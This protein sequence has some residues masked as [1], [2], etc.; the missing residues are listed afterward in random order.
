ML[1]EGSNV[2]AP[3]EGFEGLV[4]IMNMKG[5]KVIKNGDFVD[6]VA[7]A[8]EN[9][10]SLGRYA[11]E[12]GLYGIEKLSGI[13]GSGGAVPIQ[14][15]GAYG[16]E[17]KNIVKWVEVFDTKTMKMVR[18]SNNECGFRYRDSIF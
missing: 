1:G 17:V 15:V 5:R 11:L 6:L 8:G 4:L 7:C 13:P 14:N 10:D 16:T 3:D 12:R 9:C 18:L 2:L